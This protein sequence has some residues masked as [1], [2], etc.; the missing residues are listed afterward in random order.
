M[1]GKRQQ[2]LFRQFAKGRTVRGE[3]NTR[4]PGFSGTI[5][6]GGVQ[7]GKSRISVE[8]RSKE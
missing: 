3:P 4:K 1:N 5:D 7:P 6:G 8:T 2:N